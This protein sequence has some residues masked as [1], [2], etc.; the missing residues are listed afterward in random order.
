MGQQTL[1]VSRTRRYSVPHCNIEQYKCSFF[2]RTIMAWN[3]IDNKTAHLDSTE[4]F[5][6]HQHVAPVLDSWMS[7]NI[8]YR[9]R[10]EK[11]PSCLASHSVMPSK[12]LWTL[13][14]LNRPPKY[15]TFVV[16]SQNIVAQQTAA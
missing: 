10:V 4:C 3:H 5:K 6:L 14:I 13:I 8:F 16:T 12:I 7:S 1:S 9:N 15:C 2:Q 11:P